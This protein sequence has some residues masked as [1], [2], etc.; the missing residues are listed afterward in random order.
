MS[1]NVTVTNS[2]NH[3]CSQG[4]KATPTDVAVLNVTRVVAW[5]HPCAF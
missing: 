5:G 1:V 2:N 3:V 4:S